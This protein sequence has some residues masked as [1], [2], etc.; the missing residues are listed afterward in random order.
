M[1]FL[2][3]HVNATGDLIDPD[4]NAVIEHGLMTK[5]LQQGLALYKVDFNTNYNNWTK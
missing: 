1:T 5:Q 2:G 3:F 4:T